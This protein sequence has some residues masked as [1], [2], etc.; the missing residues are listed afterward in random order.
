MNEQ[1]ESMKK[2]LTQALEYIGGDKAKARSVIVSAPD[3]A[4][5]TTNEK[6]L[7]TVENSA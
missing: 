4:T 3:K 6:K 2:G 1:F 7:E 5:D